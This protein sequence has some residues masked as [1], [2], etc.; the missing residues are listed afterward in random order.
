M[1]AWHPAAVTP[2]RSRTRRPVYGTEPAGDVRAAVVGSPI[3]TILPVVLMPPTAWQLTGGWQGTGVGVGSA[4]RRPDSAKRQSRLRRGA[5][6]EARA[7]RDRPLSSG[8]VAGAACRRSSRCLGDQWRWVRG[9]QLRIS[10]NVRS[11]LLPDVSLV[12]TWTT[13]LATCPP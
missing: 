11:A 1:T 6:R 10:W 12:W 8:P 13:L 5:A 2:E 4:L 7:A 3:N 9:Q